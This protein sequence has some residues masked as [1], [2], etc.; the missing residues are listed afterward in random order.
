MVQE[1]VK[2]Q[3]SLQLSCLLY[4][5]PLKIWVNIHAAKPIAS[6]AVNMEATVAIKAIIFFSL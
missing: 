5:L 6:A 4:Y 1:G 3:G 2:R